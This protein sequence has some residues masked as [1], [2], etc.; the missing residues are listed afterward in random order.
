[1]TAK[2]VHSL[3]ILDIFDEPMMNVYYFSLG[4][5]SHVKNQLINIRPNRLVIGI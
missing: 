2:F 4:L 1:M 5:L 3:R